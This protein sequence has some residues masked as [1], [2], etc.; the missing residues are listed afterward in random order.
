[1]NRA[2]LV[3][4]SLWLAT[5]CTSAGDRSP[6]PPEP[7]SDAATK[8]SAPPVDER[9]IIAIGD[10]HGDLRQTRRVLRMAGL[11]DRR[12]DWAAG[13]T[14][15]VQTGDVADRGPDTQAIYALLRALGPQA[16]AAGGEVVTLLGN[17][18]VMNMIGDLRYVHPGDTEAFGGAEARAQ[19][20]SLDGDLGSW[21]VELPIVVQ[22]QGIVFAH[23]GV[24]ERWAK[25][26]IDELNRQA[27]ESLRAPGHQQGRAPV[28]SSTGPLWFRGF[29][30]DP[31][32]EACPHLER[33]LKAL[34]A[35][36][37]VVGHTAQRTG[38]ILS[39]CD[40]RLQVIDIGIGSAYGGNL[41]A[42]SW[43]EGR[44][45][46]LYPSGPVELPSPSA[47]PAP[48]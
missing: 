41:G 1:M 7:S 45:V 17:H 48:E 20:F 14:I 21:L 47:G 11:T 36:R 8:R 5:G 30:R 6:A 10:L 26:G 42:W 34:G 18:E 39:R 4:G 38:E 19:A 37:M 22:I 9:P 46:A 25:E 29:A 31:E 44:A 28:L 33:S 35:H 27:K 32:S 24:S 13:N 3:L 40:G 2:L 16:E 12:G 15:F 23:G 43:S